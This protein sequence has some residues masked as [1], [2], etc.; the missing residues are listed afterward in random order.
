[1]WVRFFETGLSFVGHNVSEPVQTPSIALNAVSNIWDEQF[2]GQWTFM[3][4]TWCWTITTFFDQSI[5]SNVTSAVN[6]ML[7]SWSKVL[8]LFIDDHT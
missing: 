7:A 8:G 1:M 2:N 3:I 4:Q 6:F 5:Q